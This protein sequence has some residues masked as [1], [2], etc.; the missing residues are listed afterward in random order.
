M[1]ERDSF[2]FYRSFFESIKKLPEENQLEIYN[3]IMEFALNQN[4]VELSP[5]G[6]AIFNLIKPQLEANYKRFMNGTKA[7]QKQNGSKTEANNKQ[8]ESKTL[9]NVNVNVNDNVN[10]K[11]N[12]K[13]KVTF[14]KPSLDD[15]KNYIGEKKL[16]VDAKQFFDYFET[17]NWVDAK[18]NKV[19]NWKQK[20]LTWD[21][22][23]LG[24]QTNKKEYEV[25]SEDLGSLYDN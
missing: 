4:Q 25:I 12:I 2:V 18:G 21:K 23:N 19:K 24:T 6:E 13:R 3:A 9:T 7:K 17:G 15:I 22:F 11:E 14:I 1:A 20:L 5:L 8:T 16:K 10:I